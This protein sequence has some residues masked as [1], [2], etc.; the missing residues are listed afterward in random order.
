MH[1]PRQPL[2]SLRARMLA[3][4]V[5]VV[6]VA[7][8][9]VAFGARAST[10]NEFTRYVHA[11]RQDMQYV[12]QEVAA[13]TGERMVVTDTQGVVVLDSSNELVG[14]TLTTDKA[15]ALGMPLPPT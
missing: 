9:T 11:S 2:T 1:R 7:L 15:I 8:A 10:T 4:M 12:V 13:S 3:L 6:A 14:E 5:L